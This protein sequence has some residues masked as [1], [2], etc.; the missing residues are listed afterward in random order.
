MKNIIVA[1]IAALALVSASIAAAS[2]PPGKVVARKTVSGA[3]AVGA[4]NATVKKPTGLWVRF[5][6]KVTTGTVVVACS[7]G[8]SISSNSYQ[9]KK[10]GTYRIPIRPARAD[11]CE[12]VASVGGSGRISIE[13][14]AT[15]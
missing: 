3:F 10:A 14:R 7:R 2:T 4:I 6:G 1:G 9:Y 12:L 8:F 5:T 13:L 15:R 11:S